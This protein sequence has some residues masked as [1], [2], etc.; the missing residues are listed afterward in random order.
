VTIEEHIRRRAKWCGILFYGFTGFV[1]GFLFWQRSYQV[2]SPG[3][4]RAV[5]FTVIAATMGPLLLLARGLK[6]PRC[7][8]PFSWQAV[9]T[10]GPFEARACPKCGLDFTL[11]WM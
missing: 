8:N 9:K 3:A 2:L 7:G 6:C 1:P 10:T 4:A 5:V 11:P